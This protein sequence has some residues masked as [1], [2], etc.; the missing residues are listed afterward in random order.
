MRRGPLA[1]ALL[2]LA[3]LYGAL[4]A[5]RRWWYRLGWLPAIRLH[6]PVIVV[7]NR[8]AGG[9]GKT[10][11]TI[12]IVRHLVA[13]GWRVGIV[14]RGHER[15]TRDVRLINAAAT[16]AEVGDEPLL[17][18]RRTSSTPLAVGRDRVAAAQAL[19]AA[20]PGLDIIVCDD[21]L[22]HLR[23]A[24]DVEVIVFDERGA[25]NSWLL[26]AGPL[27]ESIH[28]R[29]SAARQITL[30]NAAHPS[31]RIAGHLAQR[32]MSGACRLADWWQGQAPQP[33]T[34]VLEAV[35]ASSSWLA[36]AGIAVPERF[37]QQLRAAGLRVR[38]LPLADHY[39][40]DE[41]PWPAS[42][43]LIVLTEKDAIK[44]PPERLARQRPD[45][46]VW[47]AALDFTPAPSF[48]TELDAALAAQRPSQ[49]DHGQA[50]T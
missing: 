27:R 10:P 22:Q 14:S 5:L 37:F 20:H 9:A 3:A 30:Y 8:V 4:T 1:V 29:N 25:G 40:F 11:T 34:T 15:Q 24:R 28:V 13:Q 32:G 42:E 44:L 31:T 47:V 33:W 35:G 38:E 41:W 17:I 19:L 26:P 6:V 12:A 36:A 49:I 2:P 7:G 48:L 45:C 43:R 39:S 18:W 46:D 16:A 50:R 23:L 21:G